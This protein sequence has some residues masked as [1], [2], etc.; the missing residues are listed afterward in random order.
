MRWTR[1]TLGRYGWTLTWAPWISCTM[2]TTHRKLKCNSGCLT[3]TKR[4]RFPIK[5]FR[6]F[7]WVCWQCSKIFM[8]TATILLIKRKK[9]NIY[10]AFATKSKKDTSNSKTSKPSEWSIRSTPTWW[11]CCS[12]NMPSRSQCSWVTLRNKAMLKQEKA[13]F[14]IAFRMNKTLTGCRNNKKKWRIISG[15][16]RM[17]WMNALIC[18]GTFENTLNPVLANYMVVME[19]QCT[20][21]I[22]S[23]TK[24]VE[25]KSIKINLNKDSEAKI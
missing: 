17:N 7:Y 5:S 23:K 10:L 20:V 13:T 15:R 16:C 8:E 6:S 4:E 3:N 11:I 9:F 22:Q 24:L 18:W 25:I 19:N 2:E 12:A 14:T 1:K 21:T